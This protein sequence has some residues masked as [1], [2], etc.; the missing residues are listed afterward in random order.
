MTGQAGRIP[1]VRYPVQSS[2]VV[3][4]RLGAVRILS[5]RKGQHSRGTHYVIVCRMQTVAYGIGVL[6]YRAGCLPAA[7]C[8][9]NGVRGLYAVCVMH[10]HVERE[11]C[12]SRRA[13]KHARPISSSRSLR[14]GMLYEGSLSIHTYIQINGMC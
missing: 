3:R 8:T 13:T 14:T 9:P 11:R 6:P 5:R 7:Q 2:A 10:T 1:G 12:L 4:R